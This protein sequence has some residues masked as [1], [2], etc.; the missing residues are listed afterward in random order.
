MVLGALL[1]D[2][3]EMADNVGIRRIFLMGYSAGADK[4]TLMNLGLPWLDHLCAELVFKIYL[5]RS[6]SI[7]PRTGRK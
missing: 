7:Q 1:Q 5:Q 4:A 6:A 2:L 3:K